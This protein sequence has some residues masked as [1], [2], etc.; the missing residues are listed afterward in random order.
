M[1]F[2]QKTLYMIYLGS[3]LTFESENLG[4]SFLGSGST[5]GGSSPGFVPLMVLEPI[6][7]IVLCIGFKRQLR[8]TVTTPPAI[9]LIRLKNNN[10]LNGREIFM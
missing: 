9:P 3:K 7:A 4:W 5:G 10:I 2:I 6:V 1:Y 8:I